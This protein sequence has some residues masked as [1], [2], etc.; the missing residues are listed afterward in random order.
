MTQ[1]RR[2]HPQNGG[3]CRHCKHDL[4][5]IAKANQSDGNVYCSNTR[6]EFHGKAYKMTPKV[7]DGR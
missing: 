4:V 5:V 1:Q 3:I 7:Q 6:C 2:R